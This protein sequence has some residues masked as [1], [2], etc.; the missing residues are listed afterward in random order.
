MSQRS[1]WTS[2]ALGLVL[3]FSAF[4]FQ[5]PAQS[6]MQHDQAYGANPGALSFVRPG[7]VLKIQ[8][9]AIASDGTIRVTFT[10]ADPKGLPLDLDGINTPGSVTVNFVAAYIPTGQRQYVSYT[11]QAVGPPTTKMSAN[12]P[13]ADSGGAMTKIADGQY[14]Y[15]FATS[16]GANYESKATHTIGGFAYRDLTEFDLGTQYSNDVYTFVP[17]GGSVTTARDIIRT[18]SCDKCHGQL[19]YP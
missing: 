4:L 10:I 12:L 13:H 18:A 3:S 9:A 2:P 16:V 15:V 19:N 1:L 8:S 5:A 6:P 7:L 11:T 14:Q 17:G